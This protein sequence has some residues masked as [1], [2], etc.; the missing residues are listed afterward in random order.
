MTA[1]DGPSME[2]LDQ[3]A[4][5]TLR[6]L[7]VDMVEEARSG[8]Y[9]YA[10]VSDGDLMEGISSEAASLAGTLRLGKLVYLYDDNH[11]SIEGDT[12]LAF[13]EDV[14]RRFEAYGWQVLHVSDGT[15]LD[16]IEAAIRAAQE[17]PQR[18]S[19]VIM[20][21]HIGHGSPKQDTA[22]AHGEPQGAEAVRATKQALGWPPEPAFHIP[23]ESLQ[24]FRQA[25]VLGAA[26]EEAWQRMYDTYRRVYPDLAAAFEQA[27]RG[28]LPSGWDAEVPS[29]PP[30]AGP[31]ATRDASGKIMNAL[32]RR[33]LTFTGGSADL[34]SSTKTL[35]IGYGDFGF[36]K[37]YG[38]NLHF[39]VREHAMGAVVNGMALHGGVIP[40]GATFLV[41]SDYLRPALRLA[42]LMQTRTIFLF[43]HDSIAMGEDGPTH[44]PV[45]HL[46][47][48]R[49]IPGLRVLRP[50]DANETAAAWRVAITGRRPVALVL[51]RQKLPVL[52]PQRYPVAEGVPRG[53][54]ILAEA[55]R[56]SPDVVLIATGSEVH[57]ALGARDLLAA[58]GIFARVVSMPSW[59][60][61]AAQTDEYRRSVL[62]SGAP[63][64]VVEAGTTGGWREYVG[65]RGDVIGIDRFGASA[66]GEVVLEHYGF[67][68]RHV[69]ER[70]RRLIRRAGAR[71][72]RRAP[73]KTRKVSRR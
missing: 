68:A 40:Y 49:A 50:G 70:A 21:T 15:D 54:Y 10:I 11:I 35:L 56:G 62:P 16:A 13:A 37:A 26:W 59:E 12:D 48:L 33:V 43:T 67:T 47:S 55:E 18:P 61:F 52:D 22:A 51:T 38:H 31:I 57:L 66:P 9:T 1:S 7:T 45:E 41:F 6:F 72:R 36:S 23:G 19:L 69:A 32:A 44:Q 24:Q 58:D 17:E 27:V 34:A 2:D 8:H 63:R 73:A 29:F 30:D 14:R 60:V 39:G 5:N 42:A 46:M 3:A 25:V 53:A 71:T 28:E 64:L 20:R 65:D 4:V